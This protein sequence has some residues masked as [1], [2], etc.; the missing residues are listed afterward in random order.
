MAER[1]GLRPTI[2]QRSD[3]ESEAFCDSDPAAPD[4]L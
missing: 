1:V 2:V 4:F 3:G